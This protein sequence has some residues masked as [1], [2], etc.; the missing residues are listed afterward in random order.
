VSHYDQG[1]TYDQ[2][3]WSGRNSLLLAQ[4]LL[5]SIWRITRLICFISNIDHHADLW[6]TWGHTIFIYWHS[7]GLPHHSIPSPVQESRRKQGCTFQS[8]VR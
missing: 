4:K 6:L 5:C 1:E 8:W 3:L 7:Y 2:R